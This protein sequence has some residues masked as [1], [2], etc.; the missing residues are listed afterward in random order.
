MSFASVLAGV[1]FVANFSPKLLVQENRE[2]YERQARACELQVDAGNYSDAIAACDRA[3]AIDANDP[4]VW[5][6]RAFASLATQDYPGALL[7]YEQ[8]TRLDRDNSGAFAGQCESHFFLEQYEEA[9]AACNRALQIDG[10]WGRSS[11]PRTWYYRGQSALAFDQSDEAFRAFDWAVQLQ[12]DYAPALAGQCEIFVQRGEVEMALQTCQQA[13]GGDWDGFSPAPAWIYRARAQV[14]VGEFARALAAYN[15][16]IALA[17]ENAELWTEQGGLLDRL[18]RYNEAVAS[19]KLAVG[20]SPEFSLALANLC[21]ALNHVEQG[22]L[23]PARNGSDAP[24]SDTPMDDS[25]DA[26]EACTKAL[27][28]GDGRWGEDGPA[29][30]WA[31]GGNALVVRGMYREALSSFA[32]SLALAPKR[33][34]TWSDRAVAL[35]HLERF[36]EALESVET[37]VREDPGLARGWFNKGRILV[38]TGRDGEA[39]IAYEM[40]L[41]A[42]GSRPVDPNVRAA[43]LA[44]YS[45]LLWRQGNYVQALSLS[46][47]AVALQPESPRVQLEAWN[48]QSFALI[49]L[50]RYDAARVANE[51]AIA[52]APD[53]AIARQVRAILQVGV[54]AAPA[55]ASTRLE[56]T[57]G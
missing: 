39:A 7:A 6:E 44:N 32:R 19:H 27:Q 26:P 48:N 2:G 30:A 51:N 10:E 53:N 13:A 15:Q 34:A 37:A 18:G 31:E 57:G 22:S 50:E 35:W 42:N 54:P 47:E 8:V 4:R 36:D 33:A 3:I 1:T 56:R 14:Q 12:S 52:I 11:P 25:P 28:E 24:T 49:A 46:Q 45:A 21:T 38:T 16:A 20:L 29:L 23:P 40:A 41:Q 17:P 9:I 43:V 5:E 55:D